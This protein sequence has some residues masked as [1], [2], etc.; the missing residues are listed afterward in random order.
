MMESNF[1]I[2]KKGVLFGFGLIIPISL[3]VGIYVGLNSLTY[4]QEEYIIDDPMHPVAEIKKEEKKGIGI[5]VV[6]FRDFKN[7]NYTY[8][9]GSYKNVSTE[10]I[11]SF[12]IQADFFDKDGNF[13]WQ[14]DESVYRDIEPNETR[15]FAIKCG[16]H[17]HAIPEYTKVVMSAYK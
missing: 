6:N 14:E 12:T 17:D 8:I 15:N 13:V 7:G 11:S 3:F 2:F 5:E 10:K 16:C 4:K 9:V 1:T